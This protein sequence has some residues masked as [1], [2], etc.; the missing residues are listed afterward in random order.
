M[1]IRDDV[2]KLVVRLAPRPVCDECVAHTLGLSMLHHVDQA[3][4]ELAGSNGFERRKDTC[5]LC[6]ET[7]PV[8]ARN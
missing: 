8:T 5:S 6:G 1:T 2:E 7:R 4:R 3:T